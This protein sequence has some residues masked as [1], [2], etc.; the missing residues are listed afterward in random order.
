LD[1]HER[2]DGAGYPNGKTGNH[3]SVF[4][5][6][7][8]IADVYDALISNRPYRKGLLPSEAME[9]IMGGSGT[10]FDPVFVTVFSRKVA[11]YP[12]GMCVKLSDGRKA[13]V[14]KN[15]E[16]Y[17]MRPNLKI[18]PTGEILELRNINNLTIV[19]IACN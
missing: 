3:I 9:Y 10:L 8:S 13:L 15:F 4:G 5:R 18:I 2:Y 19:G 1:H 6:I 17:S 16:N 7:I 11:A 12:T 14:L